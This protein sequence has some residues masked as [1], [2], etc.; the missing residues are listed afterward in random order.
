MMVEVLDK[1]GSLM[2]YGHAVGLP[3]GFS[4]TCP[5]AK[6]PCSISKCMLEINLFLYANLPLK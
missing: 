6:T 4:V 1:A 2:V 3:R 5:G